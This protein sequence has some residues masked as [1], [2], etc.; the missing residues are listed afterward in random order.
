MKAKHPQLKNESKVYK[1]LT[2]GIGVPFVQWF[3]TEC[4]YNAMVMDLLAVNPV[5]IVHK[6]PASATSAL[7]HF[8]SSSKGG[9][10]VQCPVSCL[11]PLYYNSWLLA[12]GIVLQ[13]LVLAWAFVLQSLAACLGH[14]IT[15][16]CCSFGM[17][18][19]PAHFG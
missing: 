16:P 6:V 7:C 4:D 19:N 10:C 5:M 2:G 13:S 8:A 1:T 12:W 15:I 3:G 11:G 14:C 18:G 17:V 9:V